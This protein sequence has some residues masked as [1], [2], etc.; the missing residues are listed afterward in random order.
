MRLS[1]YYILR[2]VM[3][4]V[5]SKYPTSSVEKWVEYWD[6]QVRIYTPWQTALRQ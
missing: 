2:E 4:G 3:D 5:R 1:V 6:H